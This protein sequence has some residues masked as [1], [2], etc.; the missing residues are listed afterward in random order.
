[1]RNL[2]KD[3]VVV[4]E[5]AGFPGKIFSKTNYDEFGAWLDTLLAEPEMPNVLVQ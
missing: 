5:L 3:E 1:M 2:C 4:D